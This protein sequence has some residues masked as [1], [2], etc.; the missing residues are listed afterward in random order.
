[1]IRDIEIQNF[2][3]FDRTKIEG[4]D[5]VNLIGGKNN[6]GKTALLEALIVANDPDDILALKDLRKESTET[7]QALPEQTLENLYFERKSSQKIELKTQDDAG[8]IINTS[9]SFYQ[10]FSSI[11]EDSLSNLENS[12]SIDRVLRNFFERGSDTPPILEINCFSE[13]V[14][15]KDLLE[16]ISHHLLFV[17]TEVCI[18]AFVNSELFSLRETPPEH[19]DLLP[20]IPVF[21]NRSRAK[22]AQDYERLILQEKEKQQYE[23]LKAFQILDPLIEKI[24]SFSIGSPNLYLTRKG[25][26][27]LPIALFGDAINR[28]ARIVLKLLNNNS[29]ILLI[30]EIENGIHYT[31]QREFWQILFRLAIELD[32]QIFA[33]THSLEMI[34]AFADVGLEYYPDRGAYFELTKSQRTDKIIGVKWE[35]ELLD[36][37]LNNQGRVRGETLEDVRKCTNEHKE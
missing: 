20:V 9:V 23:V 12:E 31:N 2:R 1:M 37:T 16:N 21:T 15:C 33:T 8:V 3:C 29:S 24:E 14:D 22:I 6:S 10:D 30:D 26:K 4:F 34:R 25:E 36:Y 18:K 19:L 27:R 35:L 32:T 28:L 7:N 13:K 11:P 17:D 5:R